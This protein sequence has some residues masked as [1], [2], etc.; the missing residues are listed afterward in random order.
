MR[1]DMDLAD[2]SKPQNTATKEIFG[3]WVFGTISATG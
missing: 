3:G 2:A 1:I